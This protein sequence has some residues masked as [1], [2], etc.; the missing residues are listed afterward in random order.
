VAPTNL[1]AMATTRWSPDGHRL[2][3]DAR[4]RWLVVS[5]ATPG[6]V[7]VTSIPTTRPRR[8]S[9][10][11][12]YPWALIGFSEDGAVLYGADET[13]G[14]P[15][16]RP[17]VSA[18][19]GTGKLTSLRALP[20]GPGR[21]LATPPTLGNPAYEAA[22]DARTG[23]IAT[24]ACHSTHDCEVAI[25]KNGRATRLVLP[26]SVGG[27]V[28]LA[29]SEG[30]IVVLHDDNSGVFVA[31]NLEILDTGADLRVARRVVGFDVVGQHGRLHAVTHD[32]A[33]LGFGAGLLE[34][35]ARLL[36]VRLSDSAG[37]ALDEDGHLSTLEMYGFAGWVR[38]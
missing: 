27:P 26:N 3:V 1:A 13:G 20:T 2:A 35:P 23:R 37:T 7:A 4:G 16:F 22:L 12:N 21:R 15:A 14:F 31:Q 34:Q 10:L 28:D 29:W 36:L 9:G 38:D 6:N 32:Y 18:S 5:V 11:V 25:W 8:Q 19:V 33:L 30:S 17:A 24:A